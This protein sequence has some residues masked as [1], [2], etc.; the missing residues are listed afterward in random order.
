MKVPYSF[1]DE[2]FPLAGEENNLCEKSPEEIATLSASLHGFELEKQFTCRYEKL[3]FTAGLQELDASTAA[4][5][6]RSRHAAIGGSDFGRSQ[7]QQAVLAGVKSLLS[8][9]S[10]WLKI[11]TLVSTLYK[12]VETTL[13]LT[14][15][16]ELFG[17]T[18]GNEK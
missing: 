8:Q 7:R 11:P 3:E 1:T 4:K 18:L 5:F 13:E 17:M 10:N 6:V 12:N 15:L 14:D 9:P 2:F 16:L